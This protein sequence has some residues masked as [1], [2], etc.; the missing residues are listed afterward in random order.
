MENTV[1]MRPFEVARSLAEIAAAIDAEHA[2][3]EATFHE[4]LLHARH[5]GTLLLEAKSRLSHG[6]WL[7]WLKTNCKFSPRTAQ[8]YMQLAEHWTE[9]VAK[10]GEN[11]G[12]HAALGLLTV[13]NEILDGSKAT[14][15]SYLPRALAYYHDHG[16]I[17]EDALV[18][19]HS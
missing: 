9:V 4:G 7:S 1:I 10:V 16:L 5:A 2:K 6:D 18:L 13:D 8:R 17:C 15:S 3:A 19:C 11:A 12:L 14:S